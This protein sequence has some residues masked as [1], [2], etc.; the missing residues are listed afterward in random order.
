MEKDANFLLNFFKTDDTT[1]PWF[2]AP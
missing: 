1:A 2:V